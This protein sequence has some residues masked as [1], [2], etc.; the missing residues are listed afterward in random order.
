MLSLCSVSPHSSAPACPSSGPDITTLRERERE[1][2]EREREI[3][4]EIRR[5]KEHVCEKSR[6][7]AQTWSWL[8]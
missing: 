7:R 4:T 1:E 8:T 5:E 6:Y 2:R 3:A